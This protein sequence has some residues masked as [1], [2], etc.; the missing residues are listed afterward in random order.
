M[1]DQNDQTDFH[2][3][4]NCCVEQ[5]RRLRHDADNLRG[6][7]GDINGANRCERE[8]DAF[9]LAARVL[10]AASEPRPGAFA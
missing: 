1:S 7:V 6:Y 4:V 2:I 5:A 3:V 9:V 10:S 8:A